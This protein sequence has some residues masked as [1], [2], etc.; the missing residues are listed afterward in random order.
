MDEV[1][2]IS[3]EELELDFMLF[4]IHPEEYDRDL[5]LVK[6]F[7]SELW[8]TTKQLPKFSDIHIMVQNYNY[9]V[10]EKMA[11]LYFDKHFKKQMIVEVCKVN[12]CTP[13]E[14]TEEQL[15]ETRGRMIIGMATDMINDINMTISFDAIGKENCIVACI[16]TALSELNFEYEDDSLNSPLLHDLSFNM[17]KYMI[18]RNSN[19]IVMFPEIFKEQYDKVRRSIDEI[20]QEGMV[21]RKRP[22]KNLEALG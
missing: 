21:I 12:N 4:G 2:V 3:E 19:Q 6:E 18:V 7:C 8:K 11:A 20:L 16:H 9:D 5:K 15:K 22:P 13:E 14:L 17:D 1:Q 10:C